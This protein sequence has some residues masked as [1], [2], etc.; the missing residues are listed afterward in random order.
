MAVKTALF[1]LLMSQTYAF[2]VPQ[3]F[4]LLA[5]SQLND[6]THAR[7]IWYNDEY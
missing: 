1:I 6:W 5:I 7:E 2:S 3:H 4:S